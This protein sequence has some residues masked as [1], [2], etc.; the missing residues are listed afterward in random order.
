MIG[1]HRTSFLSVFH[2]IAPVFWP[3]DG[4]G[5]HRIGEFDS[6]DAGCHAIYSNV[7]LWNIVG[8]MLTEQVCTLY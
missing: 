2:R 8:N 1:L 6:D 7:S 3:Y 5:W 4:H